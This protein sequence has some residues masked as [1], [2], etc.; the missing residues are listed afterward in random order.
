MARIAP[1]A[2][3]ARRGRGDLVNGSPV[4]LVG[5]ARVGPP[6]PRPAV[7][8]PPAELA[9]ARQAA[10][11]ACNHYSP[12]TDRCRQCGCSDTMRRRS[13]SRFGTCPEGRW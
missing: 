5:P 9:A 4:N 2:A 7:T 6:T 3:G 11:R 13:A 1:P 8:G 12:T 10:C